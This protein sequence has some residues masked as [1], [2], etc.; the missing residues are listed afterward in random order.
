MCARL[1]LIALVVVSIS[2]AQPPLGAAAEPE[3]KWVAATPDEMVDLSLRAA[4]RDGPDALARTVLIA[5]FEEEAEAGK[6][7]AALEKLGKSSARVAGDARWIARMITPE[8]NA[9]WRGLD[10]VPHDDTASPLVRTFA[11]LGPFEDTGGGLARTEGPDHSTH[12]WS[13]ADYSW[14]VYAVRTQRSITT[15]VTARGLPLDLYVHP[16]RES[17][18]YLGTAVTVPTA[19]PIVVHVAAAGSLRVSWDHAGVLLDEASHRSAIVDRAAVRIEAT[20]GTHLLGMKVCSGAQGDAGRVRVRFAKDDGADLPLATSSDPATLDAAHAALKKGAVIRYKRLSTPL[21]KTVDGE[22]PSPEQALAAAVVLRLAGTDDQRSTRAPG[23]LDTLAGKPGVATDQLALAGFL[24]PSVANQSG[25]LTQAIERAQAHDPS[26]AAFAQRSLVSL[27]LEGDAID[28][29]KATADRPPLKSASDPHARWLRARLWSEL[30]TSGLAQKARTELE[31]I[32][33]AQGSKT[34]LTVWRSLARASAHTAERLGALEHLAQGTTGDRGPTYVAAHAFVG[35]TTLEQVALR[36]VLHQPRVSNVIRLGTML[37]DAGRYASAKALLTL[38]TRLAPN[39]ADAFHSLARTLRAMSPTQKADAATL[40]L[41][42]RA[43]E[44]EPSD[45]RLQAELRFRRGDKS[46]E[47]DAGEDAQYIVDAKVFLARAKAKPAPATGLFARQLHWRRVVRMLPDKRVSQMMHYAREIIVPPRTEGERFER[48]PGGYGSELLVA[49]VHK[50]NGAVVAPE[51]QDAAGPMVRWPPLERGDVVEIAVRN[52]TPGP[53][54]RRGD[55]PFYFADYVGSVDTNP[56]LYNDVVIDAPVGSPLAFDVIGGKADEH[57]T[58]KAN[59]RT[60]DHLIWNDP[61]SIADEPFSPSVSELMPMVVG[62]IYPSWEAFLTWY[63]GAVEGFTAPDEQIKRMAEEITADKKTRAEK[64]NALFNFVAD[65]IRYVNYQSGEWWLPNRPQHL[66]ARRQGDCDDKAMLLISLLKAVGVDATEVLIQTRHTAQR[67]VMQSQKVAIPMFDHGIVYLPDESGEGGRFLDATSPESRIGPLPAMDSGAMAVLV[68]SGQAIQLTASA[69]PT[70]HGVTSTWTMKLAADGSGT[71]TAKE[72]H[73][74][75]MAFRLRTHLK[76]EDTR[77]QWVENNLVSDAFPGLTME[78]K[79]AFDPTLAGGAA[80]VD[81]GATT[82]SMARREGADLVVAVAPP[83][84]I[85]MILA[86]LVTR[87]LPVEL[88]PSI[89]PTHRKTVVELIAPPTHV[90]A[91][92]PPDGDADGGPFGKASLVFELS[93]D[94]KKVTIRR[95]VTFSQWRVS[96]SE[97]AAWRSWLQKIDGLL[98]RTVR[99][100]PKK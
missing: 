13:N 25:W 64:V 37:H 100:T 30:G 26:T 39:R 77:P 56:I 74:G 43:A 20:A 41:Y 96:V 76:E 61:P 95:D 67:R 65:D 54:G 2:T 86:P 31:A 88:P 17:C 27:R 47:A 94:S 23:L 59:G 44:L 36:E 62:S 85:T 75:D 16:R 24:A 98:Q 97:Y 9:P 84:P 49:R 1:A 40:A 34:P 10:K 53:V 7:L 4:L 82:S 29:A 79:V 93:K 3:S 57:K 14:G 38:A 6:A 60:I 32:V 19:M 45:A 11:I 70:D 52:W 90:F 63:Q 89:A 80:T 33:K 91:T 58:K 66:L 99:L 18:T 15:S 51:E 92:L 46:Q 83:R 5:S 55:A 78:P 22:A 42:E 68:K 87:T 12:R 35:A 81:Y 73:V 28:L 72:V 48:L 50:K 21:E 71:L 69:P 8:V